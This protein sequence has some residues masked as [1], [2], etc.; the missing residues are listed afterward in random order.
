MAQKISFDPT[1][2]TIAYIFF[3]YISEEN[4][5]GMQVLK[6]N[7]FSKQYIVTYFNN[8]IKDLIVDE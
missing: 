6:A 3:D 8:F 4:F 7:Y 5:R 2:K 1:I